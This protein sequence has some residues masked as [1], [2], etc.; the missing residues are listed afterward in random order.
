LTSW[1]LWLQCP[2]ED[3][4]V[5]APLLSLGLDSMQ[6]LEL[7]SVLERKFGV[8]LPEAVMFDANTDLKV[9]SQPQG[10]RHKRFAMGETITSSQLQRIKGR[11]AQRKGQLCGVRPG[12]CWHRC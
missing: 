11:I 3:I 8:A 4:S 12:R 10:L 1:L 2:P 6:G 7:H 9:W 5:C